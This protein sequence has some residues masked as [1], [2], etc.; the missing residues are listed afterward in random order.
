[1]FQKTIKFLKLAKL[2]HKQQQK[3]DLLGLL[4]SLLLE[5]CEL[6]GNKMKEIK[7]LK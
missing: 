1:M 3:C 7:M 6:S 4:L 5:L 2:S